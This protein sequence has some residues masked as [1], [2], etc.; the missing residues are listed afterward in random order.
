MQR[1]QQTNRAAEHE[2][3]IRILGGE[4]DGEL[5]FCGTGIIVAPKRILTCKHVVMERYSDDGTVPN[6]MYQRIGIMIGSTTIMLEPSLIAIHATLDLAL[7][8]VSTR[9]R[10]EPPAFLQGIRGECENA[11]R[12]VRSYYIRGYCAS[13]LGKE[14]GRFSP[15]HLA[16]GFINEGGIE[17]LGSIQLH[18]G[19]PA[20]YSGGPVFLGGTKWSPCIGI[21]RLGGEKS[22]TSRI[23]CADLVID[24]LNTHGVRNLKLI[25]ATDYLRNYNPEDSY[26]RQLF[27]KKRQLVSIAGAIISI[28]ILL[29]WLGSWRFLSRH[30]P[31]RRPTIHA[32]LQ[33]A[34]LVNYSIETSLG[35][36][37][38]EMVKSSLFQDRQEGGSRG[39]NLLVLRL[40]EIGS[41]AHDI[42]HV[43]GTGLEMSLQGYIDAESST[44]AWKSANLTKNQFQIK[45]VPCQVSSHEDAHGI[46]VAWGAQMVLWGRVRSLSKERQFINPFLTFVSITSLDSGS[47][48]TAKVLTTSKMRPQDITFPELASKDQQSLLKFLTGLYAAINT[49]HWLAVRYFDQIEKS[50]D[51]DKA[52]TY[53]LRLFINESRFRAGQTDRAIRSIERI[54]KKCQWNSCRFLCLISRSRMNSALGKY[55]ESISDAQLALKFAD[56]DVMSVIVNYIQLGMTYEKIENDK[57]A[58]DYYE[59]ALKLSLDN[60]KTRET[61]ISQLHIAQLDVSDGKLEESKINLKAAL[62]VLDGINRAYASMLLGHIDQQLR[63]YVSAMRYIEIALEIYANNGE[64]AGQVSALYEI[65]SIYRI[66]KNSARAADVCNEAWKIVSQAPHGLDF[67]GEKAKLLICLADAVRNLNKE[68]QAV[69]YYEMVPELFKKQAQDQMLPSKNEQEIEDNLT[70]LVEAMTHLADLHMSRHEYREAIRDYDRAIKFLE[71]T[72]T[73]SITSQTLIMEM[74]ETEIMLGLHLSMWES[75]VR[76]ARRVA[77][78]ALTKGELEKSVSRLDLAFDVALRNNFFAA[79]HAIIVDMRKAQN[80]LQAVAMEARLLSIQGKIPA[81]TKAY[82]SVLAFGGPKWPLLAKSGLE[83]LRLGGHIDGCLGVVVTTSSS[84]CAKAENCL[85]AGDIVL[86]RDGTCLDS[87]YDVSRLQFSKEDGLQMQIWRTGKKTSVTVSVAQLRGAGASPY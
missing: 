71:R 24:F 51:L 31:P 44:D 23:I 72:K 68:D 52:D 46:G 25:P 38:K 86:R 49:R 60:H 69:K 16:R 55:S 45:Y 35:E 14:P 26:L 22:A 34:P 87:Y 62:P 43:L 10:P 15:K 19:A 66:Q 3:V 64:L 67:I 59:K 50:I 85:R 30:S 9:L 81:A 82:T 7:L 84:D 5:R 4:I 12:S 79:C 11:L 13:E 28:C 65:S 73:P 58:R 75:I 2:F 56:A 18:G 53:S 74:L 29:A 42:G 40:A 80:E 76:N 32:S 27:G 47:F 21:A 63:D 48:N 17:I 36:C 33:P 70:S 77:S 54:Q 1:R 61:A 20:G 39:L 57:L 37:R 6:I 8:E 78:L 83:R 41:G